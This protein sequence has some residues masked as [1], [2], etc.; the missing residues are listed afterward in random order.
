MGKG[1]WDND[2]AADNQHLLCTYYVLSC[3][4][5]MVCVIAL[6]LTMKHTRYGSYCPCDRRGNEAQR[7]KITD[8]R[9]HRGRAEIQIPLWLT[10]WPLSTSVYLDLP[11][12]SL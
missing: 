2:A 1:L 6:I 3:V 5:C 9:S 8:S 12:P 7:G 10:S 11:E 4:Q